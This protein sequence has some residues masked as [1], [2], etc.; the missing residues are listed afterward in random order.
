MEFKSKEHWSL[1]PDK[2]YLWINDLSPLQTIF[3][4]NQENPSIY[5]VWVK[6][7]LDKKYV[8]NYFVYSTK[9]VN[10]HPLDYAIDMVNKF[11]ESKKRDV[12]GV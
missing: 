6:V 3:F 11:K 10:V 7:Y 4:Q 2:D 1:D 8:S 5:C 12:D 9:D